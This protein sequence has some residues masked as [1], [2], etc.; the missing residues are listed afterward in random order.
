MARWRMKDIK[1]S[2]FKNKFQSKEIKFIESELSERGLRFIKEYRFHYVRRFRLDY[3]I[4]ALQIGIEYEGIVS[5]KSRHTTITGYTNDCTKY[6]L[7]QMNG[8]I[9]LRYTALN[10][11]EIK[12]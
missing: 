3:F 7:A 5:R 6:N 2:K 9:V 4:P 12:E 1:K 10:Y 11:K 8:I